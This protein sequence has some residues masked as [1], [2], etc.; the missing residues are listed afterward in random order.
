MSDKLLTYPQN[1]NVT[2]EISETVN[3]VSDA[4]LNSIANMANR[5]NYKKMV[6]SVATEFNKDESNKDE[7]NKDAVY[8]FD[9]GIGSSVK[10]KVIKSVKSYSHF[11]ACDKTNYEAY[12]T[13]FKDLSNN[14]TKARYSYDEG[15]SFSTDYGLMTIFKRKIEEQFDKIKEDPDNTTYL[16]L[17]KK[18]FDELIVETPPNYRSILLKMINIEKMNNIESSKISAYTIYLIQFVMFILDKLIKIM[19]KIGDSNLKKS[20]L[21]LANY[22]LLRFRIIY[23]T[24]GKESCQRITRLLKGETTDLFGNSFKVNDGDSS[25]T[26]KTEM[27]NKC[28]K[29]FSRSLLD[30]ATLLRCKSLVQSRINFN[31][32]LDISCNLKPK[33]QLIPPSS[34][35]IHETTSSGGRKNFTKRIKS[36]KNKRNIKKRR[37]TKKKYNGGDVEEIWYCLAAIGCGIG[38]MATDAAAMGASGT[39]LFNIGTACLCLG[40]IFAIILMRRV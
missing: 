24:S 3:N 28:D 26:N 1:I 14:F 31:D 4:S 32:V 16:I 34:T 36:M 25:L 17:N 12:L 18:K 38:L 29:K 11:D 30:A 15:Y 21:V 8:K 40:V 39:T 13:Y 20:S 5:E 9:L 27:D 19:E 2:N 35:P 22:L 6:E 37:R 7:S 10:G 33:S 23:G